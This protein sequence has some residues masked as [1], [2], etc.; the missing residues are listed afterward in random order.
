VS[1][2][3]AIRIEDFNVELDR[4][5]DPGMR[6]CIVGLLNLVQSQ[7]QEN[8]RLH[9]EIQ[10]LRDENARLKGEQGRPNVKPNKPGAGGRSNYSSEEQRKKGKKDKDK[11][12]KKKKVEIDRTQPCPVD[13]EKLPADA[14]YKGTETKVIQ[15]VVFHRDNVAFEREKFYSPSE[16]KTYYG[17]LPDGYAGHDFGPGVRSFVLTLYYAT[18][19]SEPK[20][21]ELLDHA[22]VQ[23]SAG[24][25]SNILIHEIDSFHEEKDEVQQAGLASSPWHQID[26]TSTRVGGVNH[27][28]HVLVNP[29][30]TIYRTL[31]R[32]DRPTVLA[33]L[34]GTET[35]RYLVNAEAVMIAAGLN[36]SESVLGRFQKL[37]SNEEMDEADFRERYEAELG[38]VGKQTRRKLFGAAALAAYR[39]Q[40]EV[41]VVR[42]LLGDDARQFDE[43]T[44]D[45]S[46]CWVHDG[47]HYTKLIPVVPQFQQEL[48]DF[49]DRYWDYYR[50]LR[51]YRLSPSPEE[52]ERLER[53]FDELFSTTVA[54][55]ELSDRIS[56]TREKK[57]EILLV[58]S[59]PE[60][61][62]HNNDAELAARQR[63][64]KRDVSLGP[65]TAIGAKAWDTMQSIVGT[66]KKLGVNIYD[67][68]VDRVRGSGA[69]PRLADTINQ[70]AAEMSLGASW[71]SVA[72]I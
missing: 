60:L 50:E 43:L 30:Y 17:P 8:S 48:E 66:A 56:K 24:E 31:A 3:K 41:P 32:K 34:R 29:L 21:L 2:D 28:C 51:A 67:Y 53:E 57:A 13:R 20:I 44:E 36:V 38:D 26:D 14:E 58:L 52:A 18:G 55:E 39:A 1:N 47:R 42:T 54:Y 11:R 59:H 6:H 62:L 61:P 71:E 45:R 65:R 68:F 49:Q 25:I 46:L 69:V 33:V 27:Y 37:L 10:R 5:T 63:V 4:I 64:R 19:T 35:P 70:K 7:S 15:D 16:G 23:I 9:V 12:K 72:D 40:T 22:G